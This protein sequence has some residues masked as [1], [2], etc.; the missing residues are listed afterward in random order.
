MK[1]IVEH[2]SMPGLLVFHG[3]KIIGWCSAAMRDEFPVLNNS[4]VLKKVDEEKVWLIV[5]FYIAKDFRG[6][7]YL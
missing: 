1:N 3:K 4:K 5:C 7:R 6:K 2:G